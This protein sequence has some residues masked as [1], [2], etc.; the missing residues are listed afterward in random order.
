MSLNK[1]DIEELMNRIT[2]VD[3]EELLKKYLEG[4]TLEL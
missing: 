2:E 4:N 3:I 1:V